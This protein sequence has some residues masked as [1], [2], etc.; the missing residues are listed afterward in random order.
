M[1]RPRDP[2]SSL[3]TSSVFLPEDKR[4]R[5]ERDWPGEFRR[6][7]LPLIDEELFRDLYCAD[8]GRPN[9]PVQTIVGLLILKEIEDLTDMQALY[10]LD[11]DLGWHVALDLEP[12]E[13][14][15]C[16]KTLHNFR[17]RL[18]A[19]DRARVLFVD[20]VAKILLVLG[21]DTSKQ[22]LDST[23]VISNIA[24][25]SRLRLFCETARKFLKELKRTSKRKYRA[26][27]E[28][29]RARYVKDDG[30][31]SSYD[32]A[33]SSEAKRR[34]AVCA[35]DVWRLVDRFR[36]DKRVTKLESYGLL[37]RLLAEQCEIVKKPQAPV[38]G[39]ADAGEGAAPIVVKEAKNV[40]SDSMQSP[41]DADL[42]YSGHKGKGCEVQ[43]AETMDNGDKPEIITYSEVTRSCDSD[44]HATVPA[45]DD[46]AGR[47]MQPDELLAD[48][49]Y[50]STA[51][52]IELERRGTELVA[53]V[54]GRE[55]AA[56]EKSEAVDTR[57]AADGRTDAVR[58]SN[59]ERAAPRPDDNREIDKGEFEIDVRGERRARCPAGQEAVEEQCDAGTGGV[60][61]VFRASACATCPLADRCP[62]KRRKDGTRVLKTTLH[63]AV[64]A[65]RRRYQRTPEFRRRYARRAGI[66]GTN[67]ELKRVHG[68]GRL[69]VRGLKRVRLAVR[70]KTLACNVKRTL[71]YLVERARAAAQAALEGA[72]AAA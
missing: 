33:R 54:A 5:L 10:R 19:D 18:M 28:S 56:E 51:N 58:N 60:R 61:L 13:T 21:I 29:L 53:P 46:L 35:R 24:R 7:V 36:G 64:L 20:V 32:D 1:F 72:A 66:E 43:I 67:S 49:N 11:F 48:T 47:E 38:E 12:G 8:N 26:V 41:H 14:H 40:G 59:P 55:V 63:E 9:K 42:T 2:Q 50:G 16:Q 23:H 17:A 27:P 22:R 65:R 68:L 34:I 57:K 6:S 70:L 15:C 52:V 44:E 37:E 71:K 31:D 69:R 62:A 3:F 30:E 45:V 25:L 4:E 39:D